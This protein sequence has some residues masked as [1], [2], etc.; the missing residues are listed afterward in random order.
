MGPALANACDEDMSRVHTLQTQFV[1][2]AWERGGKSRCIWRVQA[3]DL[4]QYSV[5]P[6]AN[7]RRNVPVPRTGKFKQDNPRRSYFRL[8]VT[9]N[10]SSMDASTPTGR[11]REN[12]IAQTYCAC[13]NK[14]KALLFGLLFHSFLLHGTIGAGTIKVDTV[15]LDVEKEIAIMLPDM[16]TTEEDTYLCAAVH[17]PAQPHKLVGMRP[18]ADMET[19]SIAHRT[20]HLL[21]HDF[22]RAHCS[23]VSNAPTSSVAGSALDQSNT[24]QQELSHA[25]H[26]CTCLRCV[27]TCVAR[28][29]FPWG[30]S[31]AL[32]ISNGM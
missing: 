7:F 29:E 12:Q 3:E 28:E 14:M 13:L 20:L 10:R 6:T 22:G 2:G 19:V 16:P 25:Q 23:S 5:W 21:S 9:A 15:K 18:N 8:P 24:I 11:P 26:F 17:L 4:S 27:C 31:H 32:S 30:G 1:N